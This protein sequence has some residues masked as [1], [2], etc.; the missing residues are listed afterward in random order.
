MTAVH[1]PV[2]SETAAALCLFFI[3][4]IPGA[5]AGVVLINCGLSRSRNA[6]HAMLSAICNLALA[7]VVYFAV[8]FAWQGYI[9]R[10]AH[11]LLIDGKFWSWLGAERFFLRGIEFG[12]TPVSLAVVLGMFSMGLAG[13]IPLGAAAERWRLGAS[14]A[15]TA[16][17]AACTYPLFAHGVW[18]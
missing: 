17:L 14:L 5:A 18:G 10:P 2:L 13:I 4:L 1:V 3:L 9:G 8:G 7:A 6:A 15:S 16:L 12:Q 11:W